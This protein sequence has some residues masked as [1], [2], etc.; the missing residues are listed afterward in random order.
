MESLDELIKKAESG[1]WGS[2]QELLK[3]LR[4]KRVRRSDLVMKY[5]VE[6]LKSSGSLGDDVWTILEQ[7]FQ[8]AADKHD[9]TVAG[10]C[11]AKLKKRFPQSVR[12]R[13]LEGYLF[14]AKE[15]YSKAQAV[16]DEILKEDPTNAVASKRKACIYKA[17]GDYVKAIAVLNDYL[18]DQSADA[19]AWAE[20]AELYIAVNR[21]RQAM[22]CMEELIAANPDAYTNHIKYAEVLFTEGVSTKSKDSTELLIR[23][24]QYFAQALELRIRDNMRAVYGL[25]SAAQAVHFSTSV[26]KEQLGQN[27]E[28]YRWAVTAIYAAYEAKCPDNLDMIKSTFPM[29]IGDAM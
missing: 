14:E 11:L 8:S 26:T 20:L 1:A 9:Y 27:K 16:Y 12:V 22:F 7:V 25:C 29:E 18:A 24:R 2:K 13:R 23:S 4:M 6:L 15:E 21:Y 3:Y 5:G 10:T 19:T 17:K 28:V